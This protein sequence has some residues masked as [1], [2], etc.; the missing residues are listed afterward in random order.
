MCAVVSGSV[1]S[2]YTHLVH[3]STHLIFQIATSGSILSMLVYKYNINW[4]Y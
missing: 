3:K 4:N 2:V 1:Y